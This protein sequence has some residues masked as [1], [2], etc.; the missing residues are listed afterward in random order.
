MEHRYSKKGVFWPILDQT[1]I[2]IFLKSQQSIT[3]DANAWNKCEPILSI[4]PK[5]RMYWIAYPTRLLPSLSFSYI[6]IS[7]FIAVISPLG[8]APAYLHNT[9]MFP[10][11]GGAGPLV[12]AY[13]L[14][15]IPISVW[16]IPA[17]KKIIIIIIIIIQCCEPSGSNLVCRILMS[18]SEHQ[19]IFWTSFQTKI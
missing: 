3:Y 7:P 12:P 16:Y 2:L 13:L 17:R 14:H 18:S 6:C 19:K 10:G 4:V 8:A 5:F 1:S 9:S 15:D 11:G